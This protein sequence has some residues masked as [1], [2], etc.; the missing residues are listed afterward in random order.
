M[1]MIEWIDDPENDAVKSDCGRFILYDLE[2]YQFLSGKIVIRC[3]LVDNS[4]T[5]FE[6]AN[7][8]SRV[9]KRR[10]DAIREAQDRRRH[11]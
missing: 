6:Y 11:F 7:T 4:P 8:T 1:K 10:A 9:F 2:P 3:V 5:W